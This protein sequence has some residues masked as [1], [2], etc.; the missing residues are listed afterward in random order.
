MAISHRQACGHQLGHAG[1]APALGVGVVA[2]LQ[3][4]VDERVGHHAQVGLT[5]Q[6]DELAHVVVVHAVH[7]G[8]VRARDAA[9][10]AQALGFKGQGFHVA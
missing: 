6:R 10:Q 5:H 8:E 9:V 2:A 1:H 3:G 4:D 7:G